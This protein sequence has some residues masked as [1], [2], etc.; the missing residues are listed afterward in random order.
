MNKQNIRGYAILGI[1]FVLLSVLVF[2]LPMEK[3]AAFWVAYAFTAVA[4]GAQIVIGR[5]ALGREKTLKSWFL[6]FPIIHVGWVYLTVQCIAC[7][8]FTLLSGL[9]L[10][11]AVVACVF[12]AGISSLCLLTTEAAVS[13]VKR[14]EAK[15][16]KK[17]F[18]IRSLQTEAE[19]LAERE[20]EPEVKT[21]L[22]ALAEKIRYSDPMSSPQFAEL[23]GCILLKMEEL[24]TAQNKLPIITDLVALLDE[25]NKKCKI[26]K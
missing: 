18:Y 9:P 11:S 8:V 5:L 26:L 10:W 13:E 1:S 25:R 4:F 19:L 6:G 17:V 12:I 21:A 20:T 24:K 23:E 7:V 14:V 15:V 2:A 22:E 3:T 16:Q